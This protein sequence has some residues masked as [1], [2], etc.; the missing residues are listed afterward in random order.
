MEALKKELNCY[1]DIVFHWII[2]GIP[3][4]CAPTVSYEQACSRFAELNAHIAL[5]SNQNSPPS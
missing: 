4:P 2:I 3:H 5:L 1:S